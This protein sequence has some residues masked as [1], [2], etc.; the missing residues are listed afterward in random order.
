[1]DKISKGRLRVELLNDVE[2]SLPWF[3][4]ADFGSDASDVR[5]SC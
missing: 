1:M 2:V 5:P 4:S 3:G